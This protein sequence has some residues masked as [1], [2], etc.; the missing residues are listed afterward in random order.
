MEEHLPSS[1]ISEV[2]ED[3][4]SEYS[5]TQLS[6]H[7]VQDEEDN[8]RINDVEE[9]CFIQSRTSLFTAS[10]YTSGGARIRDESLHEQ[11]ISSAVFSDDFDESRSNYNMPDPEE[12]ALLDLLDL[13]E[14]PM[15]Q[16]TLT[17][18]FLMF[19]LENLKKAVTSML[20]LILSNP[21]FGPAVSPKGSYT[22]SLDCLF[23]F[24]ARPLF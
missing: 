9:T 16:S 3:G 15:D 11:S 7:D 1:A 20:L 22:F 6:L 10:S 13:E 23:V 17:Q 12:K 5:L 24:S 21:L 14:K 2:D 18:D 4:T 19:P 8:S